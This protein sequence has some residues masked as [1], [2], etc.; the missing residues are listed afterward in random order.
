MAQ[1][2]VVPVKQGRKPT[3]P[4]HSSPKGRR[5]SGRL[6]REFVG[7]PPRP[8]QLACDHGWVSDDDLNNEGFEAGLRWLVQ[9][10]GRSVEHLEELDLDLI[11][12]ATGVD[13]ERARE[14]LD[15]AGQWLNGQADSFISEAAERFGDLV[16]AVARGQSAPPTA[17]PHPLDLPTAA[18]GLALSAVDSGRW[19]VEPGSHVLLA[20][21]EGPAPADA[22]G[23]VGELRARDWINA[24]GEL[25]LVGRDALKRWIEHTGTP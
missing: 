10:V 12:H 16:G 20:G 11:A 3:Q 19:T 22:L 2:T 21:G 24:N 9:Q 18:Q 8:K 23:L 4:R 17:G 7:P 5:S 6:E 13:A 25:T 1:K 15:G 14:L